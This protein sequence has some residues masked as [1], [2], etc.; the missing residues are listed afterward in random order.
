[1]KVVSLYSIN[2]VQCQFNL[3]NNIILKDF[4]FLNLPNFACHVLCVKDPGP[5]W[6]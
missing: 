1:M 6:K 5:L 3:S 4:D 2:W